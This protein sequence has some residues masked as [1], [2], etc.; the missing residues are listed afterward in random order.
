MATLLP[1]DQQAHWNKF[2]AIVD[3]QIRGHPSMCYDETVAFNL[4][5]S[6]NASYKVSEIL[7]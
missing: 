4:G 1:K 2:V 6:V 5:T 3:Q 7:V